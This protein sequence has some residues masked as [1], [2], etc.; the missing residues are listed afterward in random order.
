MKVVKNPGA[1]VAA[2]PFANSSMSVDT[3]KD[4]DKFNAAFLKAKEA[5]V[6]GY[7]QD[8]PPENVV[9]AAMTNSGGLLGG[10]MA[11]MMGGMMG[12]QAMATQNMQARGMQMGGGGMQMGGMQM[13]GGMQGMQGGMGGM[14][15]N[16][17]MSPAQAQ[18]MMQMGQ[19]QGGM[20]GMP[21]GGMPMGGMQGGMPMGG[22]HMNR[23]MDAEIP[24]AATAYPAPPPYDDSAAKGMG[25]N[26]M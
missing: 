18:M 24:V 14:P 10:M 16:N 3:P 15:M 4:F 25:D 20:G 8:D 23:G 21:M 7:V 2:H 19:M 6:S 17:G 26:Q 11:Q 12:N 1:G 22:M 13:G 5:C 9:Q